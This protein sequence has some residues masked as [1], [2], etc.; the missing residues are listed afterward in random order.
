[1]NAPPD[2][3]LDLTWDQ[4]DHRLTQTLEEVDGIQIPG[5]ALDLTLAELHEEL[6]TFKVKDGFTSGD[7]LWLRPKNS[8]SADSRIPPEYGYDPD[9][10]TYLIHFAPPVV[11]R[12]EETGELES[13]KNDTL[14]H[15]GHDQKNLAIFGG[16]SSALNYITLVEAGLMPKPDHVVGNT[17][18]TMARFARKAGFKSA[19]SI[20]AD[21]A[22]EGPVD[23]EADDYK[24]MEAKMDDMLM[25][26]ATYKIS[27]PQSHQAVR[28]L[29]KVMAHAKTTSNTDKYDTAHRQV[30]WF[31]K[32]RIEPKP[33]DDSDDN[34]IVVWAKYEDFRDNVISTNKK[35]GEKIVNLADDELYRLDAGRR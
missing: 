16:L 19:A 14:D 4:I 9:K 15:P 26:L 12:N 32:G 25:D 17:N 33:K 13:D 24:S 28:H 2:I 23:V 20:A 29:V 35:F 3:Q 22:K 34:S 10:L 5:V 11:K 7:G 18:P 27:E 1:M 21:I 31:I 30:N 8:L 6:E